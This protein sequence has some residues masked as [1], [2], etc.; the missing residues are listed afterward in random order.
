M[1]IHAHRCQDLATAANGGKLIDMAC[2]ADTSKTSFG[3]FFNASL[4]LPIPPK[5][6]YEERMDF[7]LLL[8][9]GDVDQSI[10]PPFAGPSGPKITAI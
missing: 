10:G 2:N 4:D 7:P 8:F 9:L 5:D 3:L 6:V 1:F